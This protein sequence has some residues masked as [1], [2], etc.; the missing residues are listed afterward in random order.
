MLYFFSKLAVDRLPRDGN[1]RAYERKIRSSFVLYI[2]A[3]FDL[4]LL[5]VW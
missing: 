3:E 5:Y 4:E 1:Y 2:N